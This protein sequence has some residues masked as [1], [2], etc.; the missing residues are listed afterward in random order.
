[1]KLLNTKFLFKTTT[2]FFKNGLNFCFLVNSFV[3][4]FGIH[5]TNL[6]WPG[7]AHR[8]WH[9]A[10]FPN[11][12]C[13]KSSGSRI[14]KAKS[15]GGWKQQELYWKL[16]VT[17]WQ[18]AVTWKNTINRKII[19]KWVLSICV[20]EMVAMPPKWKVQSTF[21]TCARS[22]FAK[23]I[24]WYWCDLICILF[25]LSRKQV[26]IGR[27]KHWYSMYSIIFHILYSIY[28]CPSNIIW[29]IKAVGSVY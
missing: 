19:Y 20:Y 22:D 25:N 23:N 26:L 7:L 3:F 1:M 15:D 5:K 24:Y 12:F 8:G 27:V 29:V 9:A 17:I 10:S 18:L 2:Y 28:N 11:A 6:L 16:Q 4:N 21:G 13:A 14:C